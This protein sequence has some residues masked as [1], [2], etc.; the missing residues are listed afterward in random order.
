MKYQSSRGEV[1]GLSFKQAVLMGLASDGGLLVPEHIPDVS[2]LLSEFK[3]L[4]YNELAFEVMSRFIDDISD[5][6][7]KD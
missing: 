7:L 1:S 2:N 3:G 4:S 5:E 6:D